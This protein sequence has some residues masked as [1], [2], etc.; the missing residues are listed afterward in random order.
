MKELKTSPLRRVGPDY[1]CSVGQQENGLSLPNESL[2]AYFVN[3]HFVIEGEEYIVANVDPVYGPAD[4]YEQ[5]IGLKLN[6]WINFE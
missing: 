4:S 3:R 1:Y 6:K 5:I 2:P